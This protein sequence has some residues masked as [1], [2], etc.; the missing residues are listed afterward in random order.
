MKDGVW[1]RG[2]RRM[3]YSPFALVFDDELEYA[4][5]VRDAEGNRVLARL[6]R[7]REKRGPNVGV[8]HGEVELQVLDAGV[9]LP[10]VQ[11]GIVL[12]DVRSVRL[13]RRTL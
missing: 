4:V 9:R 7:D 3:R 12:G 8:E 5:P 6:S 11:L 2:G 10:H 1:R 13:R